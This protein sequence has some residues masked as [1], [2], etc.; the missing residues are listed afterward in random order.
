MRTPLRTALS[1]LVLGAPWSVPPALAQQLTTG[2]PAGYINTLGRLHVG[3]TD[4]VVS[5][6]HFGMAF[7][8]R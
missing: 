3:R 4:Q 2:T 5:N 8:F 7:R 6:V 1:V